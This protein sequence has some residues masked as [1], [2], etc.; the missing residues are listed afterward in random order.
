MTLFAAALSLAGCGAPGVDAARKDMQL[1]PAASSL[2]YE[3]TL[4]EPVTVHAILRPNPDR[5]RVIFVHG[6]PGDSGAWIDY[7]AEGRSALELIAIDRPGFGLTRPDKVF[8]V[9]A[10]QAKALEPLLTSPGGN[11]PILVGH[12][13]G[14]PIVAQAAVDY[15]DRI[16]GIIIAAGSLDPD[17]ER[18]D[19]YQIVADNP[20]VRWILPRWLKHTNVEDLELRAHLERLKPR[21]KDIRI[22]VMVVHGT[23]DSLVQYENV[24]FMQNW[25]T[26]TDRLEIVRLEGC[27]HFLPWNETQPTM[28]SAID[29][30]AALLDG[31]PN[32]PAIIYPAR[33][34]GKSCRESSD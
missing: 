28:W 33:G 17:L 8:P 12:S 13:L 15:P 14:G 4:D 11:K 22:P 3:V 18:D 30:M 20:P 2:T 26:G 5:R 9:T 6:T 10:D 32:P 24:A 27:N 29:R 21:L 23:R 7:I 31:D 16:G 34:E 25:M 1:P 19:W